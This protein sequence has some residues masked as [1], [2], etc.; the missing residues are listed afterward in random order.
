MVISKEADPEIQSIL[1]QSTGK[2]LEN[3]YY[4][5][6]RILKG[7]FH[8]AWKARREKSDCINW[9]NPITE[10]WTTSKEFAR[11][12][13]L[14]HGIPFEGFDPVLVQAETALQELM[15][16]ASGNTEVYFHPMDLT[17]INLEQRLKDLGHV[18]EGLSNKSGARP[19]DEKDPEADQGGRG[20]GEGVKPK[21]RR[22]RPSSTKGQALKL[23]RD[24]K[25]AHQ[26]TGISKPEFLRGRGLPETDL[27]TLERGRTADYRRRKL[28]SE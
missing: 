16:V 25:A 18:Y 17:L 26:K 3:P 4:Q 11:R 1:T 27:L 23:Y 24:W 2:P 7:L 22:G 5:L 8:L 19:E 6:A 15:Q 14:G 9:I 12:S 20:Q 21:R 13:S 10:H 28:K